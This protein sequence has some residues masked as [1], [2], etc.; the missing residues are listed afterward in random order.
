M[1]PIFLQFVDDHPSDTVAI[2][3]HT[4]FPYPIDPFYSHNIPD[5]QGRIDWYAINSVPRIKVDGITAS[6]SYASMNTTYTSRLAVSTD[7]SIDITGSWDPQSRAVAVT[8]TATTTSALTN[9]YVMH[10]V[11]TE[12]EVYY[13]ATNGIDWHEHTMR[14]ALP[15]LAGTPV[16]FSGDFPQTAEVTA[17]FTL[18]TG[19]PPHEYRPEFCE[20][21]CFVQQVSTNSGYREVQQAAAVALTDLA[22]TPVA[23]LPVAPSLGQPYPNPFNPETAIPV[24][25]GEPG[26]VALRILDVAGRRL[27]T[28]QDGHLSAGSHAFHWDG[29]DETGRPLASGVYLAQLVHAGGRESRRLVLLK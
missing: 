20:I 21:V 24:L 27:R 22:Q 28:L 29:R 12:S 4:N 25:L 5:N 1:E 23:E 7:L 6:N 26:N 17:N 14:D 3:W 2:L 8:A 9:E 18:P 13:E 19:A 15:S 10:I 11:L 16:S